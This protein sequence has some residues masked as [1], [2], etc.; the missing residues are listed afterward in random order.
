[1]NPKS[2]ALAITKAIKEGF[3]PTT[4]V[5]NFIEVLKRRGTL[6]LLPKVIL[7]LEQIEN[8]E[9]AHLPTLSVANNSD[10]NA[11]LKNSGVKESDVTKNIDETL[12]GGY[13]LEQNGKLTD[14]SHKKSLLELYYK[15]T[16]FKN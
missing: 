14:T 4:A 6:K 2:Y 12:I 8:R 13:K 3:D 9:R 16:K 11:A 1:M 7:Q 10:F 15:I 5:K